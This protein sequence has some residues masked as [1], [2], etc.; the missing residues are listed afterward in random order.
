MKQENKKSVCDTLS[1]IESVIWSLLTNF[2]AKGITKRH[3]SVIFR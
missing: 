3:V 2:M 1:G